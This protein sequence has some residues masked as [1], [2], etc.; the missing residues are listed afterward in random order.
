MFS[1]KQVEMANTPRYTVVGTGQLVLGEVSKQKSSRLW[2]AAEPNGAKDFPTRDDA[3]LWL[4]GRH[5]LRIPTPNRVLSFD[6][7]P[8]G[9][10]RMP[11]REVHKNLWARLRQERFKGGDLTCDVCGAKE[12]H[13]QRIDAHEVYSFPNPSTVH[14]DKLLFVCR[15]CHYAIHFDRSIRWCS[16]DYIR[17]V[18]EHYMKVNGGL[19]QDEFDRDFEHSQRRSLGLRDF[20]RETERSVI[21]NFGP[22]QPDVDALAEKRKRRSELSACD[23]DDDD[24]GDYE[25]FPDHECPWDVGRAD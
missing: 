18:Q 19:S 5:A 15:L 11:L 16:A 22:Y 25:M 10:I 1:Y 24:D 13:K 4:V 12:M 23:H 20:Y 8:A 7:T 6:P 3:A 2:R 17:E 14:L 21:L 9:L